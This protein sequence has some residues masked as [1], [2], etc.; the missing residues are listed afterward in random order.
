[1]N[2]WLTILITILAGA[3]AV[4]SFA[5]SPSAS[6][7]RAKHISSSPHQ[8]QQ[9]KMVI[10]WSIKSSIDAVK[11][12]IDPNTKTFQGTGVWSFIKLKKDDNLQQEEEDS[13]K[14]QG[15]VK[16][17]SKDTTV[18]PSGNKE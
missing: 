14:P 6:F 10:Y 15:A 16:D 13:S 3:K 5:T 8:R 9:L 1:M 7:F 18:F 2:T 17:G 12:A 11:Y 4:S